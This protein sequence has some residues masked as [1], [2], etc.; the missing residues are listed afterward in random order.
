MSILEFLGLGKTAATHTAA[1]SAETETV[2]KIVGA[3]DS[4]DPG[5]ARYI[6]AFAFILC[7]VARADLHISPSETSLMEHQ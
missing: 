1:T 5:R 2:R 6:A 3:L 4:M 7:R